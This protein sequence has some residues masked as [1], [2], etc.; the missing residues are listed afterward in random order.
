MA[1]GAGMGGGAGIFTPGQQTDDAMPDF[2][3][4]AGGTI[5]RPEGGLPGR[6]PHRRRRGGG[7]LMA[8]TAPKPKGRSKGKPTGEKKTIERIEHEGLL[9]CA[10]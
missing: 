9:M 4:P 10:A 2:N 6:R 8:T 3:K 5:N 1:G 7:G